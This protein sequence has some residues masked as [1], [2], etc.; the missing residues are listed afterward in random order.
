MTRTHCGAKR[1]LVI[2]V[3]SALTLVT[4]AVLARPG[5]AAATHSI[6]TAVKGSSFNYYTDVSLF[7]G[8]RMRRG[9]GQVACTSPNTPT[10]C[11]PVADAP[12]AASPSADCLGAAGSSSATDTDG[13]KATYGPAVIFGGKYPDDPEAPSQ[14]SGPLTSG[15]DCTLGTGGHA[16]AS[17]DQVLM[18]PESAY[19]GGL[20]PG[21]LVADEA[22]ARCEAT[23]AG[24]TPTVSFVNGV[25]E[26]SYD[27]TT[28][29]PKTTE[30]IPDNPA[31]GTEI[32]GTIDHVGDSFRI[33]FNEQT[34]NPDGSRTVVAAHMYLLGPTAVGDMI[35]GS[36][37]C[38][39]TANLVPHVADV[40]VAVADSPDP[41]GTGGTITYTVDV[42]NNGSEAAEGVSVLLKAAGAKAS[43]PAGCTVSKG[44]NAGIVCNLGTFANGQ[45]K[46]VVVSATA[47]KKPGSASLTATVSSTGSDPVPGNNTAVATTTVIRL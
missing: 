38:G 43:T 4:L 40:A 30:P 13:S 20:G 1:R 36:T 2:T 6:V 22:H 16:I 34:T 46:Q 42:T 14:P 17:T 27:T 3:V 5:P 11:V 23:G 21:P 9:F 10:G 28:Q 15:V 26:T 24:I 32:A 47:P 33:V 29:L 18:P 12:T 35:V 37:T 41:V 44:R 45:S 39:V 7:G 8:P 25:V 19:P 31:P